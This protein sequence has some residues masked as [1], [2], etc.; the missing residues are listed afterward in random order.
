VTGWRPVNDDPQEPSQPGDESE[1]LAPG[2]RRLRAVDG[3]TYASWDEIYTD[4]V[5][6][7]YR[8]IYSKVGN[9]PDAEDLTTEVFLAAMGPLRTTATRPEV[10]AYLVATARTVV[11]G[12]WRR[13]L[14]REVTTVDLVQDLQFLNEP[15]PESDAPVRAQRLLA[16]LPDRYR[17]VLELRFLEARSIKE[18][19]HEMGVSVAN[20][21]ILQHRALRM[22]AAGAPQ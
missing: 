11:A 7:L 21:K 18:T 1:G 20:A 8:L 16:P 22:A 17:R 19:A 5:V 2:A 3:D 6:R 15:P 12:F 9:R 10:R 4:N 14:G 13:R